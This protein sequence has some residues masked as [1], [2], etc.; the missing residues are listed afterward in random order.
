MG[1]GGAVSSKSF[2]LLNS[3]IYDLY[4][5]ICITKMIVWSLDNLV[6]LYLSFYWLPYPTHLNFDFD[7]CSKTKVNYH[8]RE[9]CDLSLN[10]FHEHFLQYK[11][12]ISKTSVNFLIPSLYLVDFFILPMTVSYKL[13]SNVWLSLPTVIMWLKM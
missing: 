9:I 6:P 12:K 10:L 8:S 1:K 13:R 4:V 7:L 2:H 11:S 3:M 5:S